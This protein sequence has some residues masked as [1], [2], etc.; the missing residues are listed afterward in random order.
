MSDVIEKL[1]NEL[2]YAHD[3]IYQGT[4][5]AHAV[6]QNDTDEECSI[7]DTLKEVGYE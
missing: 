2:L 4:D 3:M 1:I 6:G 7:C 5:I